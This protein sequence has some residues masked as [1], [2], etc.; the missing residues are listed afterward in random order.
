MTKRFARKI[1]PLEVP[2]GKFHVSMDRKVYRLDPHGM[3]RLK[4]AD[5]VDILDRYDRQVAASA[6]VNA[7]I[8]KRQE[9]PEWA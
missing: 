9:A 1:P 5:A 3:R 4:G 8:E 6:A 7:E 2:Q